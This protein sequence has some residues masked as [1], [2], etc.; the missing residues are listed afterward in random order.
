MED[1]KKVQLSFLALNPYQERNIPAPTEKVLQGKDMVEWGDKNR[2]PEFLWDLYCSVPTL[3]SIINGTKDFIV[4]D[5]QTIQVEG[6]APNVLNT[7]GQ[8]AREVVDAMAQDELAFGGFAL[9]VI[10]SASGE[11]RE[12]YPCPLRYLRFN[13]EADVFYYSEKWAKP[14]SRHKVVISPKFIPIT[15]ERWATLQPEE[16]ERNLVSIYLVKNTTTQTYPSPVYAAAVNDCET[17]RMISQFHLN[18]INNGFTSSMIVNFN[19][20]TPDDETKA[21]IE[22]DFTEKFTG[23][24]NAGRVMFSFNPDRTNAVTLTEPK[25]ENFGE[26]Y[27]ALSKH[28]RQQ[29]FTAFRANP[30]LFGIPTENLGFSQEEYESAFRLYNR[31]MVRPIQRKICDAFDHI[32]STPG[33]LTI[34]PFSLD[35]GTDTNVN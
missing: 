15:P 11:V 27:D 7:K 34:T 19:N 18:S 25:V 1:N 24:Q 22:K 21:E 29:I 35:E 16:R 9:Q 3:R 14:N 33:V 10:R 5:A 30:N 4:G 2:Y 13:K 20:G 17:E 8:T 32:F 26:R 31:T 12:V 6:Y 23:A 28:T